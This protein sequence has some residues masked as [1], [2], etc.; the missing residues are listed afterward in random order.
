MGGQLY[1]KGGADRGGRA[2]G[3]STQAPGPAMTAAGRDALR[4][5]GSHRREE[6]VGAADVA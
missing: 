3:G 6:G 5:R 1:K 2:G 4:A